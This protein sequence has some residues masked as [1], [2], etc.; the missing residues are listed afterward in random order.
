VKESVS[1]VFDASARAVSLRGDCL[2]SLR[3]IPDESIQL[4]VTSPPYNIGKDYE[5]VVP[6][7]DY[8]AFQREVIAEC[9]RILKPSGNICWQVGFTKSGREIVPLDVLFYPLFK[10]VGLFL[11]NRIVWTFGHGPPMKNRFN[12]RH[13]TVLWFAKSENSFF[14]VDAVRVPQKYPGKRHYRGPKKGEYSGHP[15]GK[16]PGDVWDIPNV[17]AHHP[18]KSE[19]QCQFPIALVQRLVRALTSEGDW[20]LDPFSGVGSA[21]CAAII[22]G[23]RGIGCELLERYADIAEIRMGLALHKKLPYRD[24]DKPI[25]T[26]DPNSDVG[27]RIEVGLNDR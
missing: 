7:A 14:D 23:R 13:E 10:D 17:K 2:D 9:V 5:D 12:G 4:I 25:Q 1:H 8:L 6:A 3:S 19:H 18:E 21:P 26:P 27:R 16:N 24:L 15:L 20:V 11:R 22:E